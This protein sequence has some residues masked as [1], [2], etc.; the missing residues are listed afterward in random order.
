MAILA[1]ALHLTEFVTS[2]M[3]LMYPFAHGPSF[4]A[5][6]CL[7]QRW[8]RAL[9]TPT[10]PTFSAGL[11]SVAP[12]TLTCLTLFTDTLLWVLRPVPPDPPAD[13]LPHPP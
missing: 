8:M 5:A 13:S 11:R 10:P 12:L 6:L 9:S 2:P 7:T 4:N 3:I 1:G